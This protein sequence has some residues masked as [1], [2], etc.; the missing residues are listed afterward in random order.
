VRLQ[1]ARDPEFKDLVLQPPPLDAAGHAA[2]LP[3]G[4]YHWRLASVAGERAGP[5]GDPQR[6][7]L[8]P[9]P[10]APPPAEPS[11][12]GD[13]LSLRWRADAGVV[14]YEAQWA[15]NEAFERAQL[16]KVD[17]PEIHLPKPDPGRYYLRARGL[18]AA[19]VAGPWSQ[20]QMIEQ[21]RDWKTWLWLAPLL[22]LW[23]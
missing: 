3:P 19:G 16:I 22:L 17:K 1:V 4:R 6:F 23:H 7:E 14:A 5:F 18:N 20:A 2:S 13:Q 10:P 15:D 8:K 9:P 11:L 21:P 12:E